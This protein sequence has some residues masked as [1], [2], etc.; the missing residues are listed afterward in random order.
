[1][2]LP[3]GPRGHAARISGPVSG[4]SHAP[5]GSPPRLARAAVGVIYGDIGAPPL[6]SMDQFFHDGVSRAADYALGGV[7]LAIWNPV[8]RTRCE[9]PNSNLIPQGA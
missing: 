4:A 6:D 8:I 9:I 3:A 1:M 5:Q 7:S 2:T